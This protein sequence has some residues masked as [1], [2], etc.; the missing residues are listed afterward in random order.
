MLGAVE[1]HGL[2]VVRP[3]GLCRAVDVEGLRE[4]VYRTCEIRKDTL[5]GC[6]VVRAQSPGEASG[7][8]NVRNR[9]RRIDA[10]RSDG[11]CGLCIACIRGRRTGKVHLKTCCKRVRP[12]GET[13]RVGPLGEWAVG[14]P[15]RRDAKV[16]DIRRIHAI[17]HV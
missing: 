4:V 5:R 9:E 11:S 7:G 2:R 13:K 10:H 17:R 14:R 12:F 8:R 3:A 1:E 16:I 6:D 15:W